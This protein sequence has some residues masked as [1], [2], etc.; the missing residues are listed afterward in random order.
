MKLTDLEKKILFDAITLYRKQVPK[1]HVSEYNETD[2]AISA[3]RSKLKRA[4]A[5]GLTTGTGSR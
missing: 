3:L 5:E 1:V 4:L 2:N